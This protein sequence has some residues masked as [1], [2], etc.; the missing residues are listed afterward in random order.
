LAILG[1]SMKYLNFNSPVLSYANESVLPFYI[2]HQPVL[3]SIGYFVV[4]WAIA[5]ALKFVIIDSISFVIIMALYELVVR[6]FN[7]LRFLFGMKLL[8][9]PSSAQIREAQAA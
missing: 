6:R 7:L 2:L 4:Q 9:K 8:A 1:F 5:D 3:L